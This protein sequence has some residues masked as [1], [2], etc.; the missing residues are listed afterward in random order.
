[1]GGFRNPK[2]MTFEGCETS[3][4]IG[5]R[6]KGYP[7]LEIGRI[8]FGTGQRF[9]DRRLFYAYIPLEFS[10]NL[11]LEPGHH[12]SRQACRGRNLPPGIG[13]SEWIQT[14]TGNGAKE[15]DASNDDDAF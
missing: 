14:A 15:Y 2:P 13:R 6:V 11:L 7:L 12:R 4:W 10:L 5:Q 1:L 3:P 9:D 8:G